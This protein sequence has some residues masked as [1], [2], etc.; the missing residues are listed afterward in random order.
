MA[1]VITAMSGVTSIGCSIPAISAAIRGPISGYTKS[2]EY[3]DRNRERIVVSEFPMIPGVTNGLN[4]ENRLRAVARYGLEQLVDSFPGQLGRSEQVYLLVGLATPARPGPRYRGDRDHLQVLL[5]ALLGQRFGKSAIR[6]FESGHPSA[7]EALDHALRFLEAYPETICI[8][9]GLDSLL[10]PETLDHFE[11]EARLKS[12]SYGRSHG[13]V[14]G[15][16]V[17]FLVV[18]SIEFAWRRKRRPL[19]EVLG[20]GLAREPAPLRS[21]DPSVFAGLTEACRLALSN[22]RVAPAAVTTVIGD[23]NGEFF[24]HK[25]WACAELRCLGAPATEREV[26]HPADCFGDVGAAAGALLVGFGTSLFLKRPSVA[27][28]ILCFC[29]DDE[30]ARGAA[31]LAPAA[32]PGRDRATHQE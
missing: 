8:V 14:P 30:G 21:P 16:G 27:E 13:L 20:V 29:S 3:A 6:F 4:R 12:A 2:K 9:A 1:A 24:R 26:W 10:D 32:A 25:E 7:L 28:T 18:E 5:L 22:A 19:A 15:E 11:S 31:V 23:L 17:G